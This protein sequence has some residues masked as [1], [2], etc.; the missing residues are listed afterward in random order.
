M[1]LKQAT[2]WLYFCTLFCLACL[3]G[4]LSGTYPIMSV[5]MPASKYGDRKFLRIWLGLALPQDL[6]AREARGTSDVPWH[7]LNFIHI[8]PFYSLKQ[9][10]P[11]VKT[12]HDWL[13]FR[14]KHFR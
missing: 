7:H 12:C 11:G 1:K 3:Y 10:P 13:A 5:V 14:T 8:A 2:G 9:V 6:K 4:C